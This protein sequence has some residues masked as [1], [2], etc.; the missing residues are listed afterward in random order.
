[1]SSCSFFFFFFFFFFS[2]AIR[3]HSCFLVRHR[4]RTNQLSFRNPTSA[5]PP[6]LFASHKYSARPC[7]DVL[8]FADA[9]SP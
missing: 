4:Q 9:F 5:P 2:F 6:M 3:M 1:M 8:D 7:C